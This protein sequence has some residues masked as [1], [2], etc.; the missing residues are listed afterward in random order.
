MQL[1]RAEAGRGGRPLLLVHGFSGGKEDFTEWLDA[2]AALG[3]HAVAPDLRGHG[4]SPKP[5]DVAQYSFPLLVDDLV[6]LA[7]A[8]WGDGSRFVLLGHSMGGM[9][10]QVL[11]STHGSRLDGLVLMDTGHGR[12]KFLDEARV[13]GLV[14]IIEDGGV[15]TLADLM[16]RGGDDP[17]AT[18]AHR[19]LVAER[20]GYAAFMDRKLRATADAAYIALLREIAFAPDRL[21]GLHGVH[22]PTLVIVGEQD[23]PLVGQSRAMAD[24]IPGAQLAVIPD[25][26]HS[27]QFENPDAWW[28]VMRD[29]LA[30]LPERTASR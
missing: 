9:V 16:A 6:E 7:D 24:A 23:G 3:W 4:E 17:L 5:D 22:V 2:L 30:T 19:R 21:D 1:A 10:A 13:D 28:H 18:P 26:G 20:D 12:V 27:P 11:A 15:A 29:F 25:A 8:V 14:G